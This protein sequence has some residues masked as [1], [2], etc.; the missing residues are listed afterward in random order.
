MQSL[1]T[2]DPLLG[3]DVGLAVVVAGLVVVETGA[4]VVVAGLVVVVAGM[5]VVVTGTVVVGAA[6][7]VVAFC[8]VVELPCAW[9]M[10]GARKIATTT[11]VSIIIAHRIVEVVVNETKRE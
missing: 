1:Q 4:V 7:V 8:V 5:V 11:A 2:A 10:A 9:T 3:F 6:V